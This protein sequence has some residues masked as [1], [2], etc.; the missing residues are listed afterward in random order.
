MEFRLGRTYGLKR[1]AVFNLVSWFCKKWEIQGLPMRLYAILALGLYL[2]L[3][4]FD[5][6]AQTTDICGRTSQIRAVILQ[7]L[8]L[9]SSDC[10]SV[11]TDDLAR[12]KK[13]DASHRG[14]SSLK[15]GDFLGLSGLETL[16]L[17]H[18]DLTDLPDDLF[19][20]SSDLETLD[21]SYNDFTSLQEDLFE[22]LSSL[23]IM[24][25]NNN[26]LTSLLEVLFD[27]LSSM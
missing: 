24:Y 20:G 1:S 12:I 16:E 13:I 2:F 19:D 26:K 8:E 4:S 10:G 15:E 21:L 18:N 6:Q 22:G 27:G 7:Q 25:L 17:D 14:I 23:E 11:P 3:F 9:E 5:S